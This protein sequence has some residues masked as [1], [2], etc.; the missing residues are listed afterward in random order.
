MSPDRDRKVATD[1]RASSP[2]TSQGTAP[3]AASGDGRRR[4][5]E[6]LTSAG[7]HPLMRS[8]PQGAIFTFDEDL[9]YLS[10]GGFGLADVGLSREMLDGKTIFEV[11]DPGTSSAI[12]CTGPR[13]SV[14]PAP[15]MFPTRGASSPSVWRRSSTTSFR[16]WQPWASPR[17]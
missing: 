4:T 3:P 10:A 16:S 11:F 12:P 8:F 5:I 9:R 1:V 15:S 13:S 7:D 14:S 17:T 2:A 6:A